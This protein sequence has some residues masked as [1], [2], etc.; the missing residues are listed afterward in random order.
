MIGPHTRLITCLA[1]WNKQDPLKIVPAAL[2]EGI[3]IYGFVSPHNPLPLSI[4][5]YLSQP[6][7]SFKG[8]D[9]NIAVLARAFNGKPLPAPVPPPPPA[10]F[11]GKPTTASSTWGA[12][13]GSDKAC[14][15]DDSTR[16]AAAPDTRSGWLEV[17]LGKDEQVGRVEILE[18]SYP[19][20]EEFTIEYKVGGIWKELDRGTTIGE[21][22]GIDFPPVTARFIRLNILK[23]NDVPTIDEFRVLPPADAKK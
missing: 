20:T 5:T 11:S 15:Y 10:L 2:Q 16:W 8:E 19:R 17:D 7:E 9:R 13:Y 6:I 23:A 3:G 12:S 4:E 18:A 1:I 21:K 14:D 22:K